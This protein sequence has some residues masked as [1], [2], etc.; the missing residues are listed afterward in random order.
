MSEHKHILDLNASWTYSQVSGELQQDGK[1]VAHGYS[2]AGDGKNNPPMEN[3]PNVGPIPRGDWNITGP[4]ADTRTHGPYVLHLEPKPETET[5]GRNG[6]LIHGD[7]K[8]HPGTASQGCIILPRPVR[9]Q[10]WTSG[11]R[12]LEVVREIRDEKKK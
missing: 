10:V 5:F 3:V 8:E 11:D 6:F 1:H 12:D 9:E 2:G 4:P 7:S